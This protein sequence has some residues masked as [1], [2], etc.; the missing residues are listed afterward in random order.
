MERTWMSVTAGI[1]SIVAGGL[2]LL[3][4]LLVGL[5]VGLFFSSGYWYEFDTRGAPSL[6][7]VWVAAFL[8]YFIISAV[9]IAGGVFALRRRLW[10]LAL[11]G[12]ICAFLTGWAWA[13]GIAAIVVVAL[14]KREFDHSAPSLPSTTAP[15]LSTPPPST[16]LS[17]PSPPPSPPPPVQPV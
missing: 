9:A 11:A 10:G 15:S 5:G 12:A 13:L 3:G 17:P 8:P 7:A 14:S 2:S 6:A 16:A 4:S 1:L